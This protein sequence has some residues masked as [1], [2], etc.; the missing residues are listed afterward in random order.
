MAGE[1]SKDAKKVEEKAKDILK[2]GGK[3]VDKIVGDAGKAINKTAK[4]ADKSV[5]NMKSEK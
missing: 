5:K 3:E 2:K 1:L 4:K